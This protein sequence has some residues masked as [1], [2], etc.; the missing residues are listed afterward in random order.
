MK[1]LIFISITIILFST[2]LFAL[3][4]QS[5]QIEINKN[6]IHYYQI[7]N[8]KSKLNLIMLTGIGTTANFWPKDF[9]DKLSHKYNLY[10]LDYRGINTDQNK[11]NLSYSIFDLANDTNVFTKKLNLKEAYLLGWSMGSTIALQTV[12]DNPKSYKKIFLI[13]PPLP[14]KFKDDA[15]FKKAPEFKNNDDI[16][17]YVFENNL[18]QYTPDKLSNEKS[19]F[20]NLN[21]NTL[22]PSKEVYAKQKIARN[23]WVSNKTSINNFVNI[24]TPT[25]IFLSKNDQIEHIGNIQK[26]ISSLKNKDAVSVIYLNDSGHAIDWDQSLK[27]ATIINTLS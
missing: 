26:T 23:N 14:T 19:R 15:K 7:D 6:K 10:I 1:K 24:K 20:I 13:S 4:I 2:K 3:D 12:F 9:I 16:Y 8:S 27:V 5:K 17:N 11:A 22:F 18:Y 25:V 21:I